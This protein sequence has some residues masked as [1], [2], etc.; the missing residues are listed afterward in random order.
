M[1]KA[2]YF[3]PVLL[4]AGVILSVK[5][6]K[7]TLSAAL[8]AALLGVCL[9][10]G[11]GYYGIL[12]AAVLF[13]LSA[14]A[15]AN[16]LTLKEALGAAEKN[17]GQRRTAQVLANVG[18]AGLF[19]LL[20]FFYPTKI[21]LFRLMMAASLASAAADTISSEMGTVYGKR[22]YNIITLKKDQKGLDGVISLKGTLFG[23]AASIIIAAIYA[24]SFGWTIN[25]WWIVIAGTIGNFADSVLGATLERKHYLGN[26]AVNFLNTVVAAVVAMLLSSFSN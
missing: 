18:A 24:F 25:F 5:T 8:T 9:Y 22:F 13:L 19:G 26:N 10:L 14:L 4:L 20:C 17:K 21:N 6:K 1:Q 12:M 11:A 2:D 23:L 3:L 16:K 15:T 7:L